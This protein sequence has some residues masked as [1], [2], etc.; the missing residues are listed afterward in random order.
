MNSKSAQ[1]SIAIVCLV[2]GIMLAIQFR[3]TEENP[4]NI[5]TARTGDITLK[6]VTLTEERDVL[7]Q[8][9]VSL[10]EKLNNVR[11][12]DQAMADLQSELQVASMYAGL[13]AVEGPGVIVTLDDSDRELYPGEDPNNLLVHDEDILKVINELKASGAEAIAV[14]DERVTSMS[15]IRCAGTTILVNWTKIAPPFEIKAVGE[16]DMLESGLA[17]RGG[18]LESLKI[19]GIETDIEK[20]ERLEIPAYAGSMRFN[21]AQP[22][23]SN[24][25]AAN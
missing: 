3:A 6:L 15:E 22:L 7:A 19:Y 16:P 4:N 2:L 8:E 23:Q 14:N 12:H 24:E 25:K 10:R 20:H 17:M 5:R 9:V 13:I 1:I 18:I 21:Y 11:E